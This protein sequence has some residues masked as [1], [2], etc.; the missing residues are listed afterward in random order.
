MNYRIV[1]QDRKIKYAGTG[2]NS[3]FDL[4]AA[5]ENVNY[6]AGEMIYEYNKEGEILWE[7]F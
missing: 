2:L 6:H 7:V 5:R 3:W 1:T 4:A